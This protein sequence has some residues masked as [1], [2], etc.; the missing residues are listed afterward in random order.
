[1]LFTDLRLELL[2]IIGGVFGNLLSLDSFLL[3]LANGDSSPK[4]FDLYIS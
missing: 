4:D 3:N 2:G 1:M